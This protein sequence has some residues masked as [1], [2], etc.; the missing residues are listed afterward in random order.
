MIKELEFFFSPA[1]DN[2]FRI[3]VEN[4]ENQKGKISH[5]PNTMRDLNTKRFEILFGY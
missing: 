2:V 4:V 5:F 3:M 1:L